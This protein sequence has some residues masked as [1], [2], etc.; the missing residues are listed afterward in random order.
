MAAARELQ[1]KDPTKSLALLREIEAGSLPRGWETLGFWAKGAGIAETVHQ[2]D[3]V[4][5]ASSWSADR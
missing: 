5:S 4:L 2:H 3:G 1:D